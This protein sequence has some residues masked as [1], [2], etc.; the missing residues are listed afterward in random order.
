MAGDIEHKDLPDALC[1]EPKG[2]STASAGTVYIADGNGAGAF[3]KLPVSS[4]NITVPT[5]ANMVAPNITTPVTVTD[6]GL[7]QTASGTL[8]DVSAYVGIPAAITTKINLT[9]SELYRFA[10]NQSTINGQVST[11]ITDIV[12]KVNQ[13]LTALKNEGLIDE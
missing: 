7:S 13:I 12:T 9:S 4:L 5:V 3:G 1:H 11:A 2:A 10:N 6:G 8:T